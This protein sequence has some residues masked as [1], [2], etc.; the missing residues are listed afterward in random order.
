VAPRFRL[1]LA[2]CSLVLSGCSV[3]DGSSPDSPPTSVPVLNEPPPVGSPQPTPLPPQPGDRI[4][5]SWKQVS[6]ENQQGELDRPFQD[7]V[8]TNAAAGSDLWRVYTVTA[9]GAPRL[10][11][12]TR[13]WVFSVS[14]LDGSN[15][16]LLGYS[17]RYTPRVNP[18]GG[19]RGAS[20][21]WGRGAEKLI[22]GKPGAAWDVQLPGTLSTVAPRGDFASLAA[23][24]GAL[25][26]RTDGTLW[27]ARL[28][29]I[30]LDGGGAWSPDGRYL[31][32]SQ[33]LGPPNYPELPLQ[34]IATPLG[35][36][37]VLVGSAFTPAWSADSSRLAF[38][39][40][41]RVSIFHVATAQTD[42]ITLTSPLL[43]GFL[44]WS[45]DGRYIVARDGLID[46]P[47]QRVIVQPSGREIIDASVSPDGRWLLMTTE[48][49]QAQGLACGAGRLANQTLL[50]DTATG[51]ERLLFDCDRFWANVEWVDSQRFLAYTHTCW[52]CEGKSRLFLVSI[53]GAAQ[54][55]TDEFRAF[56][57]YDISPDG[58][59]ILVSGDEVRVYSTTG[60]LLRS[61]PVDDG[62]TV[63]GVEW[64]P[65]GLSFAYIVGPT[66]F[67]VL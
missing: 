5:V 43:G 39:T 64:A 36:Q 56:L 65:D 32:F 52:G 16:L 33:R 8:K 38:A 59:K 67:V 58:S 45:Q 12:E 47:A 28:S 27:E 6:P 48:V 57:R 17:T 3:F 13:R 66:D 41:D 63:T 18:Q 1:I 14:W 61:I 53:D 34:Y 62:Y 15:A 22:P 26:L 40:E 50:I 23:A 35:D 11:R 37:A 55:L 29:G 24:D 10:E 54:Q 19:P 7:L 42:S 20:D 49:I 44:S 25:F 30:D 51:A 31:L 4:P 2:L 60:V 46:A 9:D 21:S